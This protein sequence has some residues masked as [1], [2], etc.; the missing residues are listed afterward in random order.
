MFIQGEG[1]EVKKTYYRYCIYMFQHTTFQRVDFWVPHTPDREEQAIRIL[2]YALL[3]RTERKKQ[4]VLVITGGPGEAKSSI[5]Q[6]L[7]EK[8]LAHRGIEYAPFVHDVTVYTPL[9]F[10]AK[11]KAL[12][13]EKRLKEVPIMI[14]DEARLLVK[15]KNWQAFLNQAIADVFALQRRVKPFLLII[16]TQDLEDIDKDVRRL[17][18]YW[19]ECYRPLNG[20]AELRI[21]RFWKNT[22]DP[23]KIKLRKRGLRGIIEMPNGRRRLDFATNFTFKMPS[24]EVWKTYDEANFRN[25]G[26]II[27]KKLDEMMA[28]MQADLGLNDESRADVLLDYYL[29]PEKYQELLFHFKRTR[30]KNWK[31]KPGASDILG[32]QRTETKE[33]VEK[34]QERFKK[35]QEELQGAV[36][37]KSE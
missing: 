16:V 24:K 14:I 6:A 30:S 17:I 3:Y 5:S 11:E 37:E 33:F 20:A 31:L 25:K 32:L 21:S 1:G 36:Q 4:T 9:E 15:A 35:F 34:A 7:T 18:T 29:K 8:L 26:I 22:S 10:P 28:R 27:K 13:E 2:D 23:E 12:L 19:G